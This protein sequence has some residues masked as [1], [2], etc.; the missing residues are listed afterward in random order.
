MSGINIQVKNGARSFT[1]QNG[2]DSY[3]AKVE[4][5]GALTVYLVSPDID[6]GGAVASYAADYWVEW[7]Y[8]S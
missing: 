2:S 3:I 6:S 5:G 4:A 7:Y 8:V 1:N